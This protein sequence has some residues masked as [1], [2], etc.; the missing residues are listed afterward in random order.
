MTD[1]KIV[2]EQPAE[3]GRLGDRDGLARGTTRGLHLPQIEEQAEG[4]VYDGVGVEMRAERQRRQLALADV[5]TTLRIQLAYLEALEDGRIDD[6][7]GPTYAVG[8][9]RTYS[10]YLGLD[11][12]EIIRQFKREV[13]LPPVDRRL[14]FPEPLDEARRPG[15]SLALISLLVAG[16]VYGGWIFLEQRDLLPIETVAEPPQRLAP[17]KPA[18]ETAP[19]KPPV[20]MANTASVGSGTG[21]TMVP[22][23]P[24][25]EPS[26]SSIP[27]VDQPA[28]SPAQANAAEASA[29]PAV[30]PPASAQAEPP[31][32]SASGQSDEQNT[33]AASE[34]EAGSLALAATTQSSDEG[35]RAA[36][37]DVSGLANAAD[38]PNAGIS[39]ATPDSAVNIG[40]MPPPTKLAAGNEAASA[41]S[42]ELSATQAPVSPATEPA[43]EAPVESA[44]AV[45]ADEPTTDVAANSAPERLNTLD[46][47]SRPVD[48]EPSQT[49]AET[50]QAS[51]APPADQ[52]LASSSSVREGSDV[53]TA[54]A[55][56]SDQAAITPPP[57]PAAPAAP[58]RPLSEGGGEG[59]ADSGV[60]GLSRTATTGALGYRPQIYGASNRDVRVVLRA[61]AESWVQVQGA[62]NELL[63]T[64]MLR[65]GD[66]YHAPNRTDLVLM[67]G[68][69]GA[70]EIMVD[71]EA[72]GTLGPL[73][74]VRR[75][76]KLTAE[77]LRGEMRPTSDERPQGN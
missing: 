22:P 10:E 27:A 20:P 74:Q 37:A 9:L 4:E 14:V 38:E 62:N 35:E 58:A 18:T 65:P 7:P 71:G 31:S 44:S 64:R 57:P 72:L 5:A 28:A 46:T 24:E 17:Y 67:T 66:S 60:E 47:V 26:V 61:R 52:D 69:A 49:A 41:G 55:M 1:R 34:N 39:A 77:Y 32:A 12:D 51:L 54:P 59:T 11:G 56:P 53:D 8:F 48:G 29:A 30:T 19:W 43:T 76:I 68:N 45:D 3:G 2:D 13:T 6:L 40:E 36:A 21:S 70:I 15:L 33:A 75:N 63:L 73:G 23:S 16:A 50:E 42:S 25:A